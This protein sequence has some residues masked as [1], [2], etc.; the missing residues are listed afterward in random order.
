MEKHTI[1]DLA[2]FGYT[3]KLKEQLDNGADVNAKSK[4]G[5]SLMHY[6]TMAYRGDIAH[7]LLDYGFDVHTVERSGVFTFCEVVQRNSYDVMKRM[8]KSGAN[9]NICLTVD[10]PFTLVEWTSSMYNPISTLVLIQ[11][12]ANVNFS[13][14]DKT[15][16]EHA[17]DCYERHVQGKQ[18]W[19]DLLCEIAKHKKE[20]NENEQNIY[21]KI[22][23][24]AL[25]KS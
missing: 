19:F 2:T 25:F 21:Q 24:R 5:Y 8:L 12:G 3:E 11:H 13:V 10:S 22:K 6:A 16:F 23:L 14:K 15:L 4:V 9:P 17:Y 18:G 20:Y 7:L 1:F